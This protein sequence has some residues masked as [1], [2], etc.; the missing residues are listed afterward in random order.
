M[1]ARIRERVDRVDGGGGD[2]SRKE[3][4]ECVEWKIKVVNPQIG[5]DLHKSICGDKCGFVDYNCGAL[6][7]TRPTNENLHVSARSTLHLSLFTLFSLTIYPFLY[8]IVRSQKKIKKPP[9]AASVNF[10]ILRTR[11]PERAGADL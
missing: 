6:R 3:R 2:F 11:S 7:T 4:K 5:T 9:C 8:L 1:C 10:D